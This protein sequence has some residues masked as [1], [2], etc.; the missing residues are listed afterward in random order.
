M[1]ERSLDNVGQAVN[2]QA[3]ATRAERPLGGRCKHMKTSST[4]LVRL[5]LVALAVALGSSAVLAQGIWKWRDKDG[6]V[7]ISDRPPP[8]EVPEKDIL[9]RPNSARVPVAAPAASEAASEPALPR[10]D[11]GLEQKKTK[12]Q[13]DQAAAEKAKKDAE[14][15]KRNQAKLETC[16]RA[17]NHMQSL[18]SG[19]RIGRTN[20]QGQREILDDNA[21]AAEMARTREAINNN[22]N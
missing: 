4:S 22:C 18:E 2:W 11:A 21:R 9:Q 5:S 15:A 20:D 3:V 6:R 10:V 17:R 8:N 16:Q 14:T 13:A 7:Q 12:A 19:V 1:C